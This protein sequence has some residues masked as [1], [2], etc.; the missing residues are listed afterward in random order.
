[1]PT[2]PG[3]KAVHESQEHL[4]V[5]RTF[6]FNDVTETQEHLEA[7]FGNL[8]KPVY[9]S[10]ELI[11]SGFGNLYKPVQQSQSMIETAWKYIPGKIYTYAVAFELG[12][13]ITVSGVDY[14]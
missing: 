2:D 4:E 11:E 7:G 8:F 10:Q 14:A 3:Y 9:E 1:M 12:T 13:G 6:I 5:G